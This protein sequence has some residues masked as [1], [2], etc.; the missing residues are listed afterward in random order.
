MNRWITAAIALAGL[1]GF[2]RA[3]DNLI[4]FNANFELGSPAGWYMWIDEKSGGNASFEAQDKDVHGGAWALKFAVKRSTPQPWQIQLTLPQWTAKPNTRYK[5]SFWAKGPGGIT[6][7]ATDA[8]KDWSYIGGFQPTLS[9][10]WTLVSGEFTTGAQ[11][12]KGK[13]GLGIGLGGLTGDYLVD[14][15]VL[16][17]IAPTKSP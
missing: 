17:E 13:V 3:A 2:A 11:S 1:S 5:L 10:T 14:D 6:V 12:G 8:D 4:P 7:G 16:E 9:P 15:V